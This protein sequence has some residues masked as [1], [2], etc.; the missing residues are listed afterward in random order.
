MG[1]G[2]VNRKRPLQLGKHCFVE[3]RAGCDPAGSVGRAI[4][5]WHPTFFELR[6]APAGSAAAALGS[7]ERTEGLTRSWAS[8]RGHGSA[9]FRHCVAQT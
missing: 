3:V 8:E 4:A 9:H 5:G 2:A 1:V 7:V 6:C